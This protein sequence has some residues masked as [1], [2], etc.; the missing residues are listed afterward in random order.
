[1]S[2]ADAIRTVDSLFQDVVLALGGVF[3]QHGCSD[4]VVRQTVASLRYIY[5]RHRERLTLDVQQQSH[6][7]GEEERLPH[8]AIEELL[9][10][11][12]E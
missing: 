3:A 4:V 7:P 9:L 6:G 2:E 10:E 11:I 12:G 8:P 1:M 5:R